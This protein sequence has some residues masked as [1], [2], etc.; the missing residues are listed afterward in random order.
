MR[1]WFEVKTQAAGT[2]AEFFIF[3]II[4]SWID[5]LWGFDDVTTAKSFTDALSTLPESVK[6]IRVRINSPGGDCFGGLTIANA[7]RAEGGK[8]R[9]VEVIVEGLAAS[10][11]S[12][13]A[14]G[15]ST[16]RMA[17]NA[18]L[19]VHA[20]WTCICG[21][22]AEM[23]RHAD[24]LDQL[25]DSLVKTYQWHSSLSTEEIV[26][27]IDGPDM[28]G[29]WLD[30]DAAIAAGLATEKVEG[31]KAAA[32]IDPRAL[33]TLAIPDAFKAQ[34]TAFTRSTATPPAPAPAPTAHPQAAADVMRACQA[35]GFAE[36]A[37]DL[38][39]AQA[40]AEQVQARITAATEAKA[41]ATAR[42]TEI[43]ALCASAKVPNL[44]GGYIGGAM[45]LDDI[46]AHLTTI[47]AALDK[48][49][50]DAGLDPDAGVKNIATGWKA[51]FQSVNRR[52]NR[53][54]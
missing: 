4:G 45:S 23:R 29:T 53:A 48:A 41:A 44:A 16:I 46:R 28:Q 37:A 8:G 50:I 38:V 36:L 47:T 21:N 14:M 31:L 9:K 13:I 43:T 6:T 42:A 17:D 40:S 33:N 12:I 30:A 49:E 18:L 27:L 1:K 34:V 19:M 54:N 26:A 32:S 51:A 11:A 24:L 22:A 10:A 52:G 20:P 5:D 2:V 7:L 25:R 15:G 39:D 35:A 3:D